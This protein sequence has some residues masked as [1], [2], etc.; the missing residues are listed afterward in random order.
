MRV[1][2]L[3]ILALAPACKSDPPRAAV[4]LEAAISRAPLPPDVAKRFAHLPEFGFGRAATREEIAAWN[5]DVRSDGVGLPPGRG[6][7][8]Q[9]RKTYAKLCVSCHGSHGQGGQFEALVGREPRRGFPFGRHDPPLPQTVGNYWPYATTLYDYINRSMPQ[10]VPGSLTP[11]EVYGLVA[12]LLYLN[13]IVPENAVMDA[14]SLPKVVM[15]AR[16]RFVM[17]NRRGGAELR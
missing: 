3:W 1:L 6:T 11:D 16:D 5:I 12:F 9:G 2:F 7:V 17:D 13:E 15:P 4:D 10:A 8:S 14:Q